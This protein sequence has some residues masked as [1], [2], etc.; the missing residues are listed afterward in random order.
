MNR[1]DKVKTARIAATL[2]L[3]KL[4]KIVGVSARQISRYEEGAPITDG[5]LERIAKA[6]QKPVAYFNDEHG[7]YIV[8][9]STDLSS[10][11]FTQLVVDASSENTS[12]A[13]KALSILEQYCTDKQK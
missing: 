2:T 5:M 12:V 4:G 1:G 8:N 13:A 11:T 6:T 9:L 7:E 10:Q 3:T